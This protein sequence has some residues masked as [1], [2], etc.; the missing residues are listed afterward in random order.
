[1][2]EATNWTLSLQIILIVVTM[3]TVP[4]LIV[5]AAWKWDQRRKNRQK[6]R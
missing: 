4:P 5:L 3:V 2:D 6:S 1:M